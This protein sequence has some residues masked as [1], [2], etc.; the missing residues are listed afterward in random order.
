M[1]KH[2]NK[3]AKKAVCTKCTLDFT[4]I[5]LR[6]QGSAV[7]SAIRGANLV[8]AT[9]PTYQWVDKRTG[10]SWYFILLWT[11]FHKI[12]LH[13]NTTTTAATKRVWGWGRSDLSAAAL[14]FVQVNTESNR[15]LR[16]LTFR[17]RASCIKGQA[18]HYSPENAFYIFN[19]QIYFIIWYLLD[20]ASLI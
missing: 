18:F 16:S 15:V 2:E 8:R 1:L 4:G 5:K 11:W 13:G 6:I 17:H 20:R 3:Q 10:K 9:P 7:Q 12:F 19:Q 14:K